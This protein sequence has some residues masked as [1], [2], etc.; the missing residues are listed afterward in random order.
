MIRIVTQSRIEQLE[1][2]FRD[3]CE[4]AR[5]TSGAA[6]EA[7]GRHVRELYTAT[8]RAERAE[9]TTSEV[10]QL[11]ARAM[12]ELS[13]AQQ[14]LLLKDIEIRRLR[15]ELEGDSMEGRTLTVLLHYGE[16]HTVYASREDAYAD[17][18]THGASPDGWVP[19]GERPA[20][21]CKWRCE[22]FIYNAA[23]NG[24]RRAYA[25]V[26]KPIGEAA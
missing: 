9:A 16:P 2:D 26:P 19:S 5:E 1:H 7:F 15:A 18:A 11:L 3:A 21:E 25:P 8:D 14:E 23:S 6:N 4:L 24:F 12:E 13:A 10:G 22:A 17:T 20:A